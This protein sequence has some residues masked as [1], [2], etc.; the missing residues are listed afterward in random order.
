MTTLDEERITYPKLDDL[1]EQHQQQQP[2]QQPLTPT[3]IPSTASQG[4]FVDVDSENGKLK[5]RKQSQQQQQV[6]TSVSFN[7]QQEEE[8]EEEYN[9][10][11][12]NSLNNNNSKSILQSSIKEKSADLKSR[13]TAGKRRQEI[14]SVVSFVVLLSLSIEKM[15]SWYFARNIWIFFLS[16]VLAMLTADFFSGIVHWAADTWGSLDTPLVGN[17]FI[18]SFREHHVVP[19]QMTKHDFIETNGD[20]CML[21]IPVLLFTAFAKV[22]DDSYDMFLQCFL[23]QLA[24]WVMLTNQIHK[25][26]HTYS[27]PSFVSFLQNYGIILSKRDH[28]VHHRNPFDKYYCITNGWLNPYLASIGF[29]K[30]LEEIITHCTGAIPRADDQAW[31]GDNV[32]APCE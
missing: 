15:F 10:S 24:F 28:A 17:S 29:W 8:E 20:N 30:R 26:S 12:E 1:I 13:Y 32:D 31:A 5:Q 16:T 6:S 4:L 11:N 19:T 7:K 23:V 21:T 22:N 14:V 18:R 2:E 9:N 25:W 27:L 3:S